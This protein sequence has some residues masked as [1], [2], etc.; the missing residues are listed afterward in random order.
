MRPLSPTV[1]SHSWVRDRCQEGGAYPFLVD[2][3]VGCP[4]PPPLLSQQQG[5]GGLD[6]A[7]ISQVI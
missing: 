4:P 1:S 5:G 2:L 7:G 6:L 3:S